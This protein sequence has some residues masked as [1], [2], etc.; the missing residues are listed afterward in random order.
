MRCA[1]DRAA[2][3]RPFLVVGTAGSVDT[4]AIDDLAAE[5]VKQ[6]VEHPESV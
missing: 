5:F 3:L 6:V 4:G 1:A 2:G